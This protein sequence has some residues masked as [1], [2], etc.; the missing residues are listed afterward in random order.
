MRIETWCLRET[1]SFVWMR[2]RWSAWDQWL[3]LRD[4]IGFGMTISGGG[5]GW[6]KFSKERWIEEYYYALGT[7]KGWSRALAKKDQSS[8]CIRSP[9]KWKAQGWLVG[10]GEKGFSCYGGRLA[11][12]NA[13]R[14]RKEC[15]ESTCEDVIFLTE[16]KEGRRLHVV[17]CRM[18]R[19]PH[20][21]CYVSDGEGVS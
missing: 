14:L 19:R 16:F 18:D 7:L 10:Y 20:M 4:R 21:G 2:L 17:G 1:E 15:L 5:R 8:Y 12:E 9:G 3:G 6:R 11:W 13:T